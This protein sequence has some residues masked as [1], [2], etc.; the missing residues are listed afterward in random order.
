MMSVHFARINVL[1]RVKARSP[2][3]DAAFL[4]RCIAGAPTGDPSKEEMGQIIKA[5]HRIRTELKRARRV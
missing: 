4:E 2:Q 3:K 1:R 5:Q